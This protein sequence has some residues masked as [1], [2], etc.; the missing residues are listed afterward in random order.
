MCCTI[1][2]RFSVGGEVRFLSHLDLLRT[3]E[4][5]LRRSGL[6]I[7]YSEGY[8]PRPKMSFGFALPVGVLSTAEYGDFDFT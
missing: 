5:A 8:S 6:P 4:R 2:F 7:A 1:R 3:M